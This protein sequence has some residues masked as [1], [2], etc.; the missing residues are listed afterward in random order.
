MSVFT[1]EQIRAIVKSELRKIIDAGLLYTTGGNQPVTST[2]R[3]KLP[4]QLANEATDKQ[5]T[6][7]PECSQFKKPGYD[8]CYKCWEK[9]RVPK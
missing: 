9:K 5:G 1:E 6:K 4:A 7:C 2:Q 3:A 8:T